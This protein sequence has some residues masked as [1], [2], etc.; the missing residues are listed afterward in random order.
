[1]GSI[2]TRKTKNIKISQRQTEGLR[3]LKQENC[4]ENGQFSKEETDIG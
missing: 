1:L 2:I 4:V 3:T